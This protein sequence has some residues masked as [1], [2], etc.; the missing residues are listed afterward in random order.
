MRRSV[1][2]F[3]QTGV[4]LTHRRVGDQGEIERLFGCPVRFE[5]RRNVLR[6]PASMLKCAPAAANSAISE[7]IR[8]YT[9]ALLARIASDRIQDR[10]ADVIRALLVEGIRAERRIVARRLNMSQ[11]TLQRA[12]QQEGTSF[13]VVRDRVRAETSEA[14]L[15]NQALKVEAVAQSVGFAETASFSRAF[16][17]WSGFSPA[18]YRERLG[19]K[20]APPAPSAEP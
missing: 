4:D 1:P 18:R 17:R 5:R 19:P 20:G 3:R 8:R 16:T 15:S 12:L 13:K 6:F 14:L 11:R 9:A 7:Q 2:G 10:A